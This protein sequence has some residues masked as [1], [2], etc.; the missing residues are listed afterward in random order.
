MP[1]A[2]RGRACGPD[3]GDGSTCA[4]VSECTRPVLLA[5]CRPPLGMGRTHTPL[6][7]EMHST[8]H[9]LHRR[10]NQRVDEKWV[11]GGFL[12]AVWSLRGPATLETSVVIC[13]QAPC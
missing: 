8:R 3:D 1:R 7:N 12:R 4:H 9:A 13:P 10:K 11:D 5:V 6:C 2:N